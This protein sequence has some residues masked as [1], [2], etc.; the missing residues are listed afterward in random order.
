MDELDLLQLRRNPEWRITLQFYEQQQ[1]VQR[2]ANPDSDG[3]I[4]RPA[5]IPGIDPQTLSTIHGRLIAYGLLKFDVGGRDT[6]VQYQLSPL[7]RRALSDDI[8]AG[9]DSEAGELVETA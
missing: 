6:G 9:E 1:Q 8:G 3:W 7:G 2:S 4:A 5:D